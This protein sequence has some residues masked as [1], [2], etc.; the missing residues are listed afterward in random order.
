ML[1]SAVQQRES[2]ICIYISLPSW[3]S[4]GPH[5]HPAP[6]GHHRAP[7]W[8]PWIIYSSF[9]PAILPMVVSIYQCYSLSSSHSPG[10]IVCVCVCVCVCAHVLT[11]SYP[12]L[13]SPMNRKLPG[14]SV[15]G[16]FQA[17][18]LEWVAISYSRGSSRPKD[19]TPTS[20]HLLQA[21]FT[22]APPRK[23]SSTYGN[24]KFEFCL[25]CFL[26]VMFSS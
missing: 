13:C 15:H 24:L 20:W 18:L 3:A 23:P 6:L 25:F 5:S 4:L 12:T 14:S 16:I 7:G 21:F 11:Q 1:A 10:E 26:A 2:S 17:R 19:L 8:S 22:I 9:S